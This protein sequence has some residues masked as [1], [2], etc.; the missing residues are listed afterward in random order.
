MLGKPTETWNG[1]GCIHCRQ[2]DPFYFSLV[3]YKM[4][5]VNYPAGYSLG[6]EMYPNTVVIISVL[7][8]RLYFWPL[9]HSALDIV[10]KNA[11]KAIIGYLDTSSGRNSLGG[12]VFVQ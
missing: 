11:S 10:Q 2:T 4:W 1:L 3:F 5:T 8:I 12:T 9:Q 6:P 7:L